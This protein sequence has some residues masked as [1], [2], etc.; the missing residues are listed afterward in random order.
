MAGYLIGVYGSAEK[1]L[2]EGIGLCLTRGQ[3]ILCEASAGPSSNGLI[4]IGVETKRDHRQHGY[5][6]WVCSCLI[7]ECEGLGLRTYWNCDAQNPASI[8]LARK[9]GYR[10]GKRYRLLAW[11][12]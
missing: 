10:S 3:E 6:T 8:A 12:G 4:E 9:L 11:L 2:Q 1:A 7:Q 5:A